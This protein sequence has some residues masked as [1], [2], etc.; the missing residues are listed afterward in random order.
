MIKSVTISANI[1][2][3]N[4]R[5]NKKYVDIIC[6]KLQW[7]SSCIALHNATLITAATCFH[8]SSDRSMPVGLCAHMCSKTT[9]FSGAACNYKCIIF[10]HIK[11]RITSAAT[12]QWLRQWT[13]YTMQIN[14]IQF[15]SRPVCSQSLPTS[16]RALANNCSNDCMGTT[17]TSD[18]W[19]E[20]A[21]NFFLPQEKKL[22]NIQCIQTYKYSSFFPIHTQLFCTQGMGEKYKQE[23]PKKTCSM[24]PQTALTSIR[25]Q[26]SQY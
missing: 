17:K 13:V 8:W 15:P 20:D 24:F 11:H 7:G 16:T 14:H 2:K 26:K 3:S 10:H 4:H 21:K 12:N 9:D 1:S 23:N 5:I 19:A 22:H 18:R 6:S 25:Q